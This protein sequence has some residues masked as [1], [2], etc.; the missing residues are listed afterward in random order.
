MNISAR[1]DD[2]EM[3]EIALGL[4]ASIWDGDFQ[5]SSSA[6]DDVGDNIDD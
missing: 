3:G 4:I 1:T 5:H 6:D 2:V